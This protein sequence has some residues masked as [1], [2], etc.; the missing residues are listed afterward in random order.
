M[1][2]GHY[3]LPNAL[4]VWKCL[5]NQKQDQRSHRDTKMT[6][7]HHLVLYIKVSKYACISD[8]LGKTEYILKINHLI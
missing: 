3:I 1:L 6:E 4:I 2:L 5:M 8:L 7:Q